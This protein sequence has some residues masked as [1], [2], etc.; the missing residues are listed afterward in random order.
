MILH[1]NSKGWSNYQISWLK[2][3]KTWKGRRVDICF[4]SCNPNITITLE[5]EQRLQSQYLM[6]VFLAAD[7]DLSRI[8][9]WTTRGKHGGPVLSRPQT[10]FFVNGF[11]RHV[12][13]LEW[14]D[15]KIEVCGRKPSYLR[16]QIFSAVWFLLCLDVY[17]IQ[18]LP[19]ACMSLE[20]D[21]SKMSSM[22]LGNCRGHPAS[23]GYI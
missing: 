11:T 19:A 17:E 1:Q 9:N 6:A 5:K 16:I 15:D 13:M 22:G 4:P 20:A 10:S 2:L 3:N 21:S 7:H 8:A 18:T 23:N 12:E 14:T